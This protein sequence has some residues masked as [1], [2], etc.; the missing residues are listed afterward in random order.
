[1]RYL[2]VDP[3]K[4]G[5]WACLDDYALIG[6]WPMILWA[7]PIPMLS[8]KEFDVDAI[9]E[10]VHTLVPASD[11]SAAVERAHPFPSSM[12]GSFA[13]FGRGES[14]AWEWLLRSCGIS[15]SR[16]GPRTWQKAILGG[17]AGDTKVRSV[18][19]CQRRWPGVDLKRTSRSR[20]P[21]HNIADAL[22]IACFD[23]MASVGV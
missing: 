21:D 12:G 2:G 3:G 1:M 8:P 5:G 14:A 23:W 4:T 16:P 19:A 7:A 17:G 6:G 20:T 9:I 15:V 18:L 13:N 11:Y 10:R 22:N